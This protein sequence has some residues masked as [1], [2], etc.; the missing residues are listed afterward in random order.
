MNLSNIARSLE[1]EAIA[2][3]SMRNFASIPFTTA[4]GSQAMAI[5]TVTVLDP[6]PNLVD[7]VASTP[8]NTAV[9]IPVLANDSDP[10]GR[11]LV[12][13]SVT[14][15]PAGQGAAAI[16]AD[17]KSVVYTP[18][19]GFLGEAQFTYDAAPVA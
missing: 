19:T 1:L 5:V 4:Q 18:A 17:Q 14:Q 6:G 8:A 13:T 12:I 15:P 2:T 10:L 11:E 7:D 16:S 3:G 9:T